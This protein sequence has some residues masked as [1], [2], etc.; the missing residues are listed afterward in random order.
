VLHW[1]VEIEVNNRGIAGKGKA[2]G[3]VGEIL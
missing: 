2:V 3:E 1:L